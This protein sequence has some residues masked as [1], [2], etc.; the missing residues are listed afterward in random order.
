M[1]DNKE[2]LKR[3]KIRRFGTNFE[4]LQVV[5]GQKNNPE[6]CKTLTF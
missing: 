4:H 3:L 6:D 2:N 5:T 1:T